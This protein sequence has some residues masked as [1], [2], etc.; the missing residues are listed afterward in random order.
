[1]RALRSESDHFAAVE[2]HGPGGALLTEKTPAVDAVAA[3]DHLHR[4][5]GDHLGDVAGF[6]PV[7]FLAQLGREEQVDGGGNRK[8][9]ADGRP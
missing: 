2:L 7:L 6:G 9:G 1:M 5:L 3:E 8:R 4:R